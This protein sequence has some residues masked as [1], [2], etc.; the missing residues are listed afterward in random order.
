MTE[1][2]QEQVLVGCYQ[3]KCFFTNM[4]VHW[5]RLRRRPSVTLFPLMGRSSNVI[6][7]LRN[8]CILKMV[9]S[10]LR[11]T[12][13][14]R[15]APNDNGFSKL[16]K[17]ILLMGRTDYVEDEGADA[18]RGKPVEVKRWRGE[19]HALNRTLKCG[20][21]ASHLPALWNTA[22]GRRGMWHLELPGHMRSRFSLAPIYRYWGF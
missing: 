18:Y 13:L 14:S 10:F 16:L 6:I 7:L 12:S 22:F 2:K 19:K 20:R 11:S 21:G 1:Q 17:Q 15:D 8:V 4:N 5:I 3:K 9:E